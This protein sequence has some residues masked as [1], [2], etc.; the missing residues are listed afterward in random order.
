M[1]KICYVHV[2]KKKKKKNIYIYIYIY[3]FFLYIYIFRDN[4]IRTANA[5][6]G[7]KCNNHCTRTLCVQR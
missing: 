1:D 6:M 3:I 4:R 7:V 5:R 2:L